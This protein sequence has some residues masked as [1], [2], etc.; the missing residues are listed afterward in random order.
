MRETREWGQAVGNAVA[1]STGCPPGP[2]GARRS[3]GLVHKS[4]G[5]TLAPASHRV[6]RPFWGR[7]RRTRDRVRAS[8]NG[9]SSGHADGSAVGVGRC[10]AV[11]APGKGFGAR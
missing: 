9:L 4:T 5:R 11:R 1:L 8:A 7:C 3:A 2:Q 10:R 6:R